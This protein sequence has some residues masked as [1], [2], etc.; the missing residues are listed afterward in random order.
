MP[1]AQLEALNT[2]S[3]GRRASIHWFSNGA[4]LIPNL[5]LIILILLG[6]SRFTVVVA[7]PP[8]ILPEYVSRL[9]SS[10]MYP[11]T[12]FTFGQTRLCTKN[13]SMKSMPKIPKRPILHRCENV[14]IKT[15]LA[16]ITLPFRI[17]HDSDGSGIITTTRNSSF[18]NSLED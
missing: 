15:K 8:V 7:K 4:L 1:L 18:K 14:Q 13:I 17:F 2:C 16:K 5:Y 6:N 10:L 11:S 9:L 3:G 12:H